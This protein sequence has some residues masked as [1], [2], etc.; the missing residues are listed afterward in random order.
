MRGKQLRPLL[1]TTASKGKRGKGR[2]SNCGLL[3]SKGST[4]Q[5]Q[6]QMLQIMTEVSKC[7]VIFIFMSMSNFILFS[8][9]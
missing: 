3:K 9:K 4:N 1:L 5:R 6:G 7:R 8:G 2:G